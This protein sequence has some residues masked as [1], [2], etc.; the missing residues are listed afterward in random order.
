MKTINKILIITFLFVLTI[1][2]FN[3]VSAKGQAPG[4]WAEVWGILKND[5][6]TEED[7]RL[8]DSATLWPRGTEYALSNIQQLEKEDVE[9]ISNSNN[10]DRAALIQLIGKVSADTV[11]QQTSE[12]KVYLQKLKEVA[13]WILDTEDDYNK[14]GEPFNSKEKEILEGTINVVDGKTN[15]D[16]LQKILETDVADQKPIEN[17]DREEY[18][19]EFAEALNQIDQGEEQIDDNLNLSEQSILERLPIGLLAQN[20][21]DGKIT[22]DDTIE[23][24]MEFVNSGQDD[25]VDQDRLQEVIGSLY[26]ILLVIAMVIAIVAGLV[27][28]I[29]FMVSGVEGKA[30]IKKVLVPYVISCAVTFGAFGIWKLVVEI[31]NNLE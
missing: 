9:K 21:S 12:N 15:A 24:A 7:S 30:E 8:S 2:L 27:I 6:L 29:K 26:N 10:W 31:L 4:Y 16:E 22:M 23:G 5:Y 17:E 11:S 14:A 1:S 18:Q 19:D 3:V 13:Q 25:I 20:N 28:A